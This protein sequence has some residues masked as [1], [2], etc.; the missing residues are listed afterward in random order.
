VHS[1]LFKNFSFLTAS[2]VLIPFATMALVVAISRL[3]GVEMLGEY[4]LLVT[5][6]FIGQTCSTA[7]LQILITRE[8]AREPT[9]AGAYLFSGS[10]L[11]LMAAVI[12]S[13]ILVPSF[14]WTVPA[15]DT[16]VA[17]LLMAGA[18][19]PTVIIAF[20]ESVLLAFE[21]AEDFVVIGF[22]ENFART[23]VGTLLVC[24]GYGIVSLAANFL[25]FRMGAAWATVRRIRHRDPSFAPGFDRACFRDLAR[26]IPI[27]GAIPVL[28]SLYWRLDT[29]L[30]TW[31]RG[32]ADVGYY[33]ASTRI[34]DITRN[35]PQ[36]YARA[37]YPILSRLRH[38]DGAEFERLSRTS[39]LWIVITTFPLSLATYTLAP[40]IIT[41]LYGA[42]MSAAVQGLRVVAWL[43]IPYA[44]TNTLAQ[45]LFAS[46]NQALDLRV[47]AVA[48]TT[49]LT[50]NL[51]F[52]PRFGFVGAAATS[53][54]SMMVHVSLQY[55][56][57]RRRLFD[58]G[59]ST[60]LTRVAGV[61]IASLLLTMVCSGYHPF[62]V[63]A[64]GITCYVLG[65]WSAGVV[66]T[67]HLIT[68]RDYT[69][70]AVRS[71]AGRAFRDRAPGELNV[72]RPPVVK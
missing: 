49:N 27:V 69:R 18:L 35:L 58:P 41:T 47:N 8:V 10:V 29:L 6:F 63:T 53:L 15:A 11:G 52:I 39:L 40:W 38:D 64:L 1:N 50:L 20:A 55:R 44:L 42:G 48:V 59:L 32:L 33:S 68:A 67:Q 71:V 26:Q 4:S 23:V 72:R 62:V 65:L 43:M 54:I 45:I 61:G 12:I 19:F 37:L 14:T 17:L 16:R 60:A 56:Y 7:G 70:T 3:G 22:V 66:R 34:L 13:A 25:V 36:A 31:L 51:L 5:F 28:N 57:V 30:L 9:K 24:T 46:G 21:R 2:S